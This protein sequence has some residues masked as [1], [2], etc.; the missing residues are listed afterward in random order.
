MKTV[1][2]VDP[3]KG[4]LS[5]RMLIKTYKEIVEPSIREISGVS[6]IATSY[7]PTDERVDIEFDPIK[8]AQ[9]SLSIEQLREAL[10]G[11]IDR[12]GDTIELGSREF[13]LHFKGRL[14]LSELTNLPIGLQ[15]GQIIRLKE[16]AKVYTRVARNCDYASING[17]KALYVEIKPNLVVM[18]CKP[19]E[20]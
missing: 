4:E 15:G 9:Y 3:I 7:N 17:Q 6:S 12:S 14:K 11:M 20:S 1:Y 16:I 5:E 2:S 18:H 8:L 10:M 19:L 13:L